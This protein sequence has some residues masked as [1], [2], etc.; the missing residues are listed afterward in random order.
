[1]AGKVKI[2]GYSQK[3]DYGNGIYYR[4]FSDNLTSS[5]SEDNANVPIF[6]S[7]GVEVTTN[8]SDRV[9]KNYTLGEFSDIY[10]LNDLDGT[11]VNVV[12]IFG[13]ESNVAKLNINNQK[14]ENMAFFGSAVE[15][16]RVSLENII[17]TWPA[18]L[19]VMNVNESDPSISGNTSNNLNYDIVT[20]KTVFD[21]PVNL[22]QNPYNINIIENS[23]NTS[24]N[25]LR[26][27]NTKYLDY[28]LSYDGTEYNVL[29]FTGQSETGTTVTITC[30]GKVFGD[31]IIGDET[32]YIKPNKVMYG[33]FYNRLTDF[34][35]NLLNN[36]TT[37]L[38]TSHF[39]I[40][41]ESESGLKIDSTLLATWPTSDGYNIDYKGPSYD[42]YVNKIH[43]VLT[44][45]D[46]N[47]TDL[48]TRYLVPETLVDF[49]T[50]PLVKEGKI[51]NYGLKMSKVLRIY[52]REYDDIRKYINGISLANIVTYDKKDNT[53][54][55]TL[56]NLAWVLGWE[57]TT[58]LSN[59]NLETDYLIPKES[60]YSGQETGYT[61]SENEFELWRR[62]ILNS[63]WIWKSKGTRKSIEFLFKFMGVPDE[64]ITLREHVYVA[65]KPLSI[66]RLEYLMEYFNNTDDLSTLPVDEDGYPKV[67]RDNNDM[68]FQKGGLWYR[69][70]GGSSPNIDINT[71]NNPHIGPYD[72]G[73]E[74]ISQF[75][76]CIIPN[77]KPIVTVTV[78]KDVSTDNLFTNYNNGTFNDCCDGNV[79]T[80]KIPLDL[81]F[82]LLYNSNVN[83]F[84]TENSV[85]TD[86]CDITSTWNLKAFIQ[87]EEVNDIDIHTGTN[88]D[89][90]YLLTPGI[91]YAGIQTL[92][93]NTT[94]LSGVT[95]EPMV[96]NTTFLSQ[97][98]ENCES[99]LFEKFIRFEVGVTSSFVCESD[100]EVLIDSTEDFYPINISS[101]TGIDVGDL[102]SQSP[103]NYL[104]KLHNGNSPI[105]VVGD[106][107]YNRDN[108]P[109]IGDEF[110]WVALQVDDSNDYNIKINSTG[111]I[112]YRDEIIVG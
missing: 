58:S 64:L 97:D 33:D 90:D 61:N 93:N 99:E 3:V 20:N 68:Y 106:R 19:K 87:G 52:G 12:S 62:L 83:L 55:L 1:M 29:D 34:E 27:L 85:T 48:I 6:S 45:Y 23:A 92:V 67:L 94:E 56:K 88:S 47:S 28:V 43:P 95:V 10:T 86:Q 59:L 109:Y 103:Y 15:L 100:C 104:P 69:Q 89:N 2:T 53:P 40:I 70:T 91:Y 81:E 16:F 44:F 78:D 79:V 98:N 22:I 112:I 26:D 9:V 25:R 74:F 30:E 73:A 37:P 54:D 14:I 66:E 24:N 5:L 36:K 38:Y 63:S 42:S 107:I 17:I 76:E 49:D 7:G 101:E 82:I 60:T 31:N 41:V 72:G 111:V 96:D 65:D 13:N 80:D 57:I 39:D 110:V 18:G 8:L 77:F 35:L 84:L 51:V 11:L 4:D 46:E 21:I 75:N 108:T 71:G 50:A 32:Y 105:P 102:Q